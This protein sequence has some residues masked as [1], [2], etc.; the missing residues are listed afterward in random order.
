MARTRGKCP[1]CGDV[2]LTV[3][4]PRWAWC[5]RAREV[6]AKEGEV[7]ERLTQKFIRMHIADCL[8]R[9]LEREYGCT[10]PLA[11]WAGDNVGWR[12]R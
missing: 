6:I 10:S 7:N 12:M 3:H 8:D 9:K 11:Q 5:S 4:K 2:F 1:H